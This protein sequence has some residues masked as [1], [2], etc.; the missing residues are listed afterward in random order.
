MPEQYIQ[1]CRDAAEN[2]E[3]LRGRDI[4]EINHA[5]NDCEYGALL[6]ILMQ[7]CPRLTQTRLNNSSNEML[8]YLHEA[9]YDHKALLI[10]KTPL[11]PGALRTGTFSRLESASIESWDIGDRYS[12]AHIEWCKQLIHLPSM[13]HFKGYGIDSSADDGNRYQPTLPYSNLTSLEFQYSRIC[14][15][16]VGYITRHIAVSRKFVYESAQFDDDWDPDLRG[17]V[18]VVAEH[19]G[20]H[21]QHLSITDKGEQTSNFKNPES[22][23]GFNKFPN[24]RHLAAEQSMFAVRREDSLDEV[25]QIGEDLPPSLKQLEVICGK[26]EFSYGLL[27][28]FASAI[29]THTPILQQLT[30]RDRATDWASTEAR[31]TL[32][33]ACAQ[34]NVQLEEEKITSSARSSSCSE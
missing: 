9:S 22:F 16:D 5:L 8:L 26:A 29:P 19:Q 18:R 7:M 25:G 3:A 1:R 17:I 14:H 33:A 31:A 13:R 21:L 34:H 23:T 4:T 28:R 2:S 15:D 30:V 24:L 11:G 12:R 6:V 10:H 32:A 27:N 20:R